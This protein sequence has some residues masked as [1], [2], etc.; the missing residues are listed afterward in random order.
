MRYPPF[1]ALANVLVRS[2][3]QEAA[4]RMAGELGHLLEPAPEGIKLLGPA[5]A[6]VE[7]LKTEFRYQLLI[8]AAS[9][10]KLNELL[11]RI[12]KYALDNKWGPTSLVIDVD[13]LSLM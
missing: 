11:S 13:P 2:E 8:K 1:S 7:R 5:Q 10:I 12:R 3:K 9:R 6:P 4:M